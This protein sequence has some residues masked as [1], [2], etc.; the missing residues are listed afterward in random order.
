VAETSELES[1]AVTKAFV[2]EMEQKIN[3]RNFDLRPLETHPFESIAAEFLSKC[4]ALSRASLLLIEAGF[5]DEAFG[6]VRTLVE[7]AANLRYITSDKD[8]QAARVKSFIDY[9]ITER[10]VWLELIKNGSYSEE[11]KAG[12]IQFAEEL[13]IPNDPKLAYRTWSGL[14]RFIITVAEPPHPLDQ[15]GSTPFFRKGQMAAD[16][17]GPSCYVHCSQ[18]GLDN[19]HPSTAKL[20]IRPSDPTTHDTS[21]NTCA[22]I[23]IHL[24]EVIRYCFYGMGRD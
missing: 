2:D 10:A 21:G 14:Q 17:H 8:K 13:R 19:Y 6:M 18:P 22:I 16:Y 4:F 12:A 7:C 20:L 23:Q 5:P 1:L 15:E 3:A 9:A 11:E 24:R